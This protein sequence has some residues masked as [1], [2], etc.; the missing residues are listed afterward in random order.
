MWTTQACIEQKQPEK[1]W[2]EVRLNGHFKR[3]TSEISHFDMVKKA[4]IKERN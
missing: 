4:K 2:E 1:I 3:Q